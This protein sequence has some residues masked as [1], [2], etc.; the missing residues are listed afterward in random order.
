MRNVINMIKLNKLIKL[1][2]FVS[3]AKND[4]W[5]YDMPNVEE[6]T[7]VRAYQRKPP[8]MIRTRFR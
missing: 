2:K 3:E 1:I 7:L 8:S 4:L 5:D 6:L